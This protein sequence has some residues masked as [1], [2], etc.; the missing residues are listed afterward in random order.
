[1]FLA[2][3]GDLLLYTA[4]ACVVGL[5]L[6]LRSIRLRQKLTTLGYFSLSLNGAPLLIGAFLWITAR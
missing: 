3:L 6:A 4:L 2:E 1:M 5:L